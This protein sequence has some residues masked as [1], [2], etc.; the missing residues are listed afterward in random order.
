MYLRFLF[1]DWFRPAL[2]ALVL[3]QYL[4]NLFNSYVSNKTDNCPLD[5]CCLIIRVM[6]VAEIRGKISG[7]LQYLYGTSSL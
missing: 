7:Y 4:A 3:L 2:L 6:T 5:I 1:S